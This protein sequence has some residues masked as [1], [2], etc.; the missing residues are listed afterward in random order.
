MTSK[1]LSSTLFLGSIIT[2]FIVHERKKLI[3]LKNQSNS[4]ETEKEVSDKLEVSELDISG[5]KITDCNYNLYFSDKLDISGLRIMDLKTNVSDKLDISGLRI[6]EPNS[7]YLELKKNSELKKEIDFKKNPKF[8]ELRKKTSKKN[9]FVENFDNSRNEDFQGFCAAG[10]C[11]KTKSGKFMMIEEKRDNKKSLNFLG[12]KRD[13]LEEEP[14][15]TAIREF[16][17]EIEYDRYDK[18]FDD[19]FENMKGVYWFAGSKY[20]L[21][22]YEITEDDCDYLTKLLS[23]NEKIKFQEINKDTELNLILHPF[24]KDMMSEIL[25]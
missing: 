6:S 10:V 4:S 15:M 11:I 18:I 20:F 2:T 17:E 12:G 9:Y 22:V 8:I 23:S 24:A 5:L 1:I 14:G 16:F 3:D 21:F 25:K 13:Y 7:K 19:I